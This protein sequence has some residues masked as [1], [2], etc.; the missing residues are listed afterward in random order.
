MQF[1]LFFSNFYVMLSQLSQKTSKEKIISFLWNEN[2]I[3]AMLAVISFCVYLTTMCRSVGFTDSGELAAVICT[4]GI[5]HPTGYPLFTLLGKCWMM[6]PAPME[7]ILQLNIFASLLT[8]AAVGI[9]FKTTLSLHRSYNVFLVRSQRRKEL[10]DNR[11]VLTSAIASLVLGFSST[12]W[13]QSTAIEVYALHLVLIL[14][15]T[16][17]F[18]EGLEEQLQPIRYSFKKADS[19]RIC[20]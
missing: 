14:L 9:F 15:S 16:L 12:F 17:F 6:I 18:I 1:F 11:F 13:S 19:L 7:E 3:A 10:N 20:N 8:A 5:A 4:L 2:I